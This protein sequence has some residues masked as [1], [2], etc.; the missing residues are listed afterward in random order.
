MPPELSFKTLMKFCEEG[1]KDPVLKNFI[2]VLS[3]VQSALPMYFRYLR[4]EQIK[5]ELAPLV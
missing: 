3:L 4:A 2:T 5:I 1:L